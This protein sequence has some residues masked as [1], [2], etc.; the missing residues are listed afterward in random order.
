MSMSDREMLELAAKAAGVG[1]ILCFESARNCLRIGDRDSYRL[2][3]PLDSDGDA[4]RLASKLEIG[5]HWCISGRIYAHNHGGIETCESSREDRERN[6]RR[7]I[8]CAAAE[9][10]KS[11]QEKN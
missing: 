5:L 8:V 2:W 3:R 4:L 9:I 1:P 10:G 11:M 7:A 6:L